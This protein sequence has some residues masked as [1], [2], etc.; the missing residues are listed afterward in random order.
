MLPKCEHGKSGDDGRFTGLW[1]APFSKCMC[2]G[3]MFPYI[4]S[5]SWG[6]TE[7]EGRSWT[8]KDRCESCGGRGQVRVSHGFLVMAT[9]CPRCRGQGS[10][11]A[12]PCGTCRGE[13]RTRVEQ[14]IRVT[15]PPGVDDG[16]RLRLGNEGEAGIRGGARG[17]LYVLVEV[18]PHE[19]FQRQGQDLLCDVP[20]TFPAA[21]LG[22]EVDVPTL[23]G[24]A[25]LK[26]PAGTQSGKGFRLRGKGIPALR[27]GGRGDQLVRVIIETPT[28]LSPAQRR[29]LEELERSQ[30][31][32]NTP[33]VRSFFERM[34]R[35]LEAR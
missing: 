35:W 5:F 25:K 23:E 1:N 32:E 26:I 3:T 6:P 9:P 34:R 20:I 31:A 2:C 17:D 4:D 28:R 29:L 11:I 22:G 24:I 21:A 13:G 19:F 27:G 12:A 18:A 7:S 33:A 10:M 16:V 15:I 8:P 14:T 30:Q